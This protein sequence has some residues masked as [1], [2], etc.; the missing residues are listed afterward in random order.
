MIT[1][2]P[3]INSVLYPKAVFLAVY[4]STSYHKTHWIKE[5]KGEIRIN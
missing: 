3:G 1:K 4:N 2:V 5:V